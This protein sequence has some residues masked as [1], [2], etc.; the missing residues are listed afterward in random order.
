MSEEIILSLP[1]FWDFTDNPVFV[2]IF[3]G[4]YQ[5]DKL[6]NEVLRFVDSEGIEWLIP[7]NTTITNALDTKIGKGDK[8]QIVRDMKDPKLKIHYLGQIPLS[9]GR[10]FNKYNVILIK[11]E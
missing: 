3:L 1:N 10:K 8:A 7:A 6:K 2:G 5:S 11:G 9:G 4:Q